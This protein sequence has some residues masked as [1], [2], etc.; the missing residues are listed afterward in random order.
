M[1]KGQKMKVV[2][3]NTL[4]K[5]GSVVTVDTDRETGW[6]VRGVSGMIRCS[7]HPAGGLFFEES[8]LTPA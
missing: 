6:I 5:S 1:E 2:V 4:I 3:G 7:I 8:N